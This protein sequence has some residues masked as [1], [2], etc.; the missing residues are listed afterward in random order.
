MCMRE[1]VPLLNRRN[2][3]RSHKYP[4]TCFA[5]FETRYRG[6]RIAIPRNP[7]SW[8]AFSS[9]KCHPSLHRKGK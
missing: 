8:V 6:S 3:N 2:Y 7:Q 4:R 5:D 1:R 9:R